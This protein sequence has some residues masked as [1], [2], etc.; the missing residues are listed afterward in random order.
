MD[1][2]ERERKYSRSALPRRCARPRVM[3]VCRMSDFRFRHSG[4]LLLVVLSAFN[5][6]AGPA[7]F[8]STTMSR[9][10]FE[11]VELRRTEENHLFAAG[12][13]NGR[14]V[15]CLVDTGWSFTTMQPGKG[16]TSSA[17]ERMQLGR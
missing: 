13:A 7:A 1:S 3:G 5:A 9:L 2:F 15:S 8:D 10:G 14:R 4:C 12:R 6:A 16:A 11:P 17:V